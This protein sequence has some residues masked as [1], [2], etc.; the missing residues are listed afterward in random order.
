MTKEELKEHCKKQIEMCEKWAK[1][2]GENPCGKIY[3][4][5]KMILELLE[6]QFC[7]DA[8]S[9][10]AVLELME[11][12]NLSMGQVVKGI[13]ALPPV[14]Q[15]PSA[16]N[17]A[18]KININENVKVKLT[19]YGKNIF[20]HQYDELNKT[21]GKEIIKPRYPKVD[22]DGYTSFQLWCFMNLYGSYI[23]MGAQNVIEP[24]EIVF[25]GAE[26]TAKW[27][28]DVDRWGDIITAINGYKCSECNAFNADKDNY[29]PNCGCR[30]KEG[31][32]E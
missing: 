24:L 30:M 11:D 13:H 10:Q 9:R 17:T 20:Y 15:Q 3:E 27:I 16:E 14:T 23:Y 12:Y 25:E 8:I 28:E 18:S 21:Y 1:A 31:D 22:S 2:K 4:E 32:K 7:E 6:Q 29:C 26:K 19:D 5:H